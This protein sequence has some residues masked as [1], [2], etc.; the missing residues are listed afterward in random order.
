M[1][2]F[3]EN[4]LAYKRFAPPFARKD[5]SAEKM[6]KFR[7]KL[8]DKL[9]DYW[10]EYGWCGYA[11]GLFWTV[12]PDEWE[13]ELD[14][15]IGDTPFMEQDTY[16]VIARTAF[17]ELILWGENSGQSLKVLTPFGMIFPKFDNAEF[18][19]DGPDLTVQLFFCCASR[20]SFDMNDADGNP[21]FERALAKLGPLDHHTMY[22]F[23][24]ALA[25][26]GRN[27]LEQ[28]QKLDAHIHL[29]ILSQMTEKQI[30]LDIAKEAGLS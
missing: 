7:G 9:L 4:F 27:S 2:R 19:E 30:M 11:D 3:M 22:G 14:E 20:D 29:S 5:V 6:A 18:R 24:P 10:Q 25:L 28:L 21:L 15:W 16:H 23:V 26:G 12:D 17:G 8:P 13:D 1:D